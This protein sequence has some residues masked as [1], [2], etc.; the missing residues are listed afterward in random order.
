M[1]WCF[2]LSN[3]SFDSAEN[4]EVFKKVKEKMSGNNGSRKWTDEQIKGKLV[5]ILSLYLS[6]CLFHL[7][8]DSSFF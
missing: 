8:I 6:F 4:E 3:G 7:L 5:V 2:L 1:Q